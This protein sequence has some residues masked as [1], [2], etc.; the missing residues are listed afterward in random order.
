MPKPKKGKFANFEDYADLLVVGIPLLLLLATGFLHWTM[1]VFLEP[2]LLLR[3]VKLVGL[4]FYIL[5]IVVGPP[6]AIAWSVSFLYRRSEGLFAVVFIV[7][8]LIWG[9]WYMIPPIVDN[10]EWFMRFVDEFGAV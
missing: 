4:P 9:F 10:W 7:L 2:N 1:Q 3:L 8:L 5:A 6:L